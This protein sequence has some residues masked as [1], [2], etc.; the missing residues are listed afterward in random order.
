VTKRSFIVTVS[1]TLHIHCYRVRTEI[2]R[3][4]KMFL[5]TCTSIVRIVIALKGRTCCFFL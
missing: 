5:N 3:D 4:K 2:C 1:E